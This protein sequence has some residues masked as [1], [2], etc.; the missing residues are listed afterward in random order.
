MSLINRANVLDQPKLMSLI[1]QNYCSYKLKLL[2]LSKITV[3]DKQVPKLLFMSI[4]CKK[5]SGLPVTRGYIL[6]SPNCWYDCTLKCGP[7]HGPLGY[8]YP[9]CLNQSRVQSGHLPIWKDRVK[10]LK[11]LLTIM[12]LTITL[13]NNFMLLCKNK[14]IN[15]Q[16]AHSAWFNNFYFKNNCC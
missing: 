5:S 15:L 7:P 13:Y 8:V 11:F 12:L 4:N 10:L 3:H 9:G 14:Q 6:T 2:I 1:S 16:Y